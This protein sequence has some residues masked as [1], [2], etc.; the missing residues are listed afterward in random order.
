MAV[1]AIFVGGTASH[2]GKSW[3]CT[4]ICRSLYRRGFR[5]AP[6]KAQNLSNNSF[7]C[8]DG[9]E[10][11]RAQAVQA[12]ACGLEPESSMN[13]VLLKPCSVT[14]S[15][16]VLNGKVWGSVPASGRMESDRFFRRQA[17]EAYDRLAAR[18]DYIVME[19]AGSIAEVNLKTLDYVNL[20]MAAYAAAQGLL[21]AD[22]DRGGVFASICG[23]LDLLDAE[24][25]A[26]IR[27][28]AVNRFRGD[29]TL[30]SDGVSFL[31]KRTGVPCVGVF[32]FSRNIEL[33]AE[34]AVTLDEI[35]TTGE[36]IAIIRLPHTSN[37]TDFRLLPCRWIDRPVPGP[38][39]WIILPGTKNTISDLDW[40]E[41]QGLASFIRDRHANGTRILGVCGGYQML[42]ESIKD[43]QGVE[44]P[45]SRSR[46][47]LGLLPVHTVLEP[48]KI[49]RLVQ[50]RTLSGT[51]FGAYE[52]HAGRTT[53]AGVAEP[54]ARVNGA[55][56]DG[57]C[58]SGVCGTYLH[59]A[60]ESPALVRE[61]FGLDIAESAHLA[62]YDQLADWFEA[63]V[64]L[65]RFEELYL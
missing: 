44:N 58:V 35:P 51:E 4:A 8:R 17:E 11:G 23:T 47:G 40:L 56:S 34:D 30:F 48:E 9:G 54:F 37:F 18:F 13:P 61:L 53:V 24:E 60:L 38:L 59:G 28:F 6:F 43:P 1:K 21:V 10:I 7:P 15:Q 57:A 29:V 32:P 39:D 22:I 46:P 41:Q 2:V 3:M 64:N 26:R 50:A 42:G 33:A 63:S 19:G 25:R 49:T 36:R 14:G 52:I 5:V 45:G 65:Q 12:E 16:V 62:H 20:S 31:E 55:G 27:S